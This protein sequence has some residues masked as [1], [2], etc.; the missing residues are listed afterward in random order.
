LRFVTVGDAENVAGI[1]H[2]G[3][4][5]LL[6]T[7]GLDLSYERLFTMRRL[8]FGLGSL[9]VILT[10]AA[11]AGIAALAGVDPAASLILGISLSLSS[12][13]IVLEVLASQGRLAT[14][15]GRASFAVL[16]AQDLAVVPLLIFISLVRT[17]ASGSIWL[18]L[19]EALEK[20]ALAAGVIVA[21]GRLIL[22]PLFGLV[23]STGA[24]DL[25]IATTLFV[26]V[27]AGVAAEGAG[28]SMAL[29]AFIIGLLLAETEYSK[30]I[31]TVIEPFKG[32]LLGLF[33]SR[34]ACR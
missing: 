28:L 29:G 16:V 9:Q 13:A 4:V 31:E 24:N 22:R 1:A 26:V 11:I 15:A 14:A 30:A 7:I 20:A 34:L 17:G 2:L 32:I 3:V 18:S 33:S 6:F 5:F 23:A 27:S 12:T 25:F 10:S 8:V 21:V 19:L